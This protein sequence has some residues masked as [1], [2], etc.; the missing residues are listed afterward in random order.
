MLLT[1]SME[2]LSCLHGMVC[3]QRL[4]WCNSRGPE[5]RTAG[6]PWVW[7]LVCISVSLGFSIPICEME[8]HFFSTRPT[9]VWSRTQFAE[10]SLNVPCNL[11]L[12]KYI[13]VV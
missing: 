6:S 11:H 10:V 13:F 5:V 8:G 7:D 3:M 9:S 4:V 12:M 2:P 1:V